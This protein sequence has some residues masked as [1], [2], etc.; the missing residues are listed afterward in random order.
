M[1]ARA[2]HAAT[3][4]ALTDWQAGTRPP[5]P[6]EAWRG[7]VLEPD[8]VRLYARCDARVPQMVRA[9]ALEE[10]RLLAGRAL[11]PGLPVMKAVGV[12]AFAAHLAGGRSLEAA[13]AEV[14]QE[15]RR[16]A[17]RQLTWFRNQT[18]DWPRQDPFTSDSSAAAPH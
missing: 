5:I 1:R 16:Y 9:G 11:D 12:R 17:K 18:P 7:L 10:V 14:G 8:R 13:I 6:R 15:T 3:G 4:R 2:V